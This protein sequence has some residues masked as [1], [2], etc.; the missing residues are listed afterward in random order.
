MATALFLPLFLFILLYPFYVVYKQ[1]LGEREPIV[2]TPEEWGASYEDIE[3]TTSDGIGLKGWWIRAESDR[4][5]LLLHGKAGCRNGFH[6]GVFDL[7]HWYHR[8]G[9]NVMMPDMRA[10]GESGGKYIYFG[11]REHA[12]MLGWIQA[13]DPSYR[14]RWVL[15]GF[16]MGAVTALMM[17]DRAPGRFRK[18]VADA[19]WIDFEGV[20]KQELWKRAH[21]PAFA[22]PYIRWIA[23]TFFGQQFKLADN[24][25]R[26]RRLC[27]KDILYI[28]EENDH[29]IRPYH[30]E[31]LKTACPEAKIV[32]FE[33][34]GHVSAFKEQ[35]A[36]YTELLE[37]EGL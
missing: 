9:Y 7:G 23:K 3:Y 19:P 25:A 22:Y 2:R 28:T 17:A 4:A 13:I 37:K 8:R 36:R 5:V 1:T 35:P 20:V 26:C 34:V 6:S 10:H 12:D 29:L 14:F 24:R 18:V 21:V 31:I 30:W 32:T 33:G 27:G 11:I 15:H 16:S